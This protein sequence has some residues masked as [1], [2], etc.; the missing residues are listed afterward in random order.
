MIGELYARGWNSGV[1]AVQCDL[2][3]WTLAEDKVCM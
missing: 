1:Y 2:E 3:E